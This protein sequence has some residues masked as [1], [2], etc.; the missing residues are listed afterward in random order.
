MVRAR[1]KGAI[2]ADNFTYDGAGRLATYQ[3]GTTN[4]VTHRFD[5]DI[6]DRV[7]QLR[8]GPV[9]GNAL[10]LTYSYN[11][12]SQVTGIA[13]YRPWM[14]QTFGYDLVD[15]LTSATSVGSY[16]TIGWTY[17]ATGNRLTENRGV[18]TGYT[19]DGSN[20][21]SG[22]TGANPETF[23]YNG[24]GE[25][26]ADGQGT[27]T[28][29]PAG[30]MKTATRLGMAAMYLYDADNMRV[31]RSV[32]DTT[33]VTLRGAGG[34]VLSELQQRCGGSL[35]WV[36]DNVYAGGKL[37]GAV[38]N[39]ALGPAT[40]L[41]NTSA[42]M[43]QEQNGSASVGIRVTTAN[44]APLACA[45]TVSYETAPGVGLT[46][47][48]PGPAPSGDYTTTAKTI[49]IPAG[50][51]HNAVVNVAVPISNDAT[52]E[53][54]ENFI[55]RLTGVTGGVL[56]LATG[57]TSHTVTIQDDDAPPTLTVN[58]ITTNE[59]AGTAN[60]TVQLSAPSAKTVQVTYTLSNGTADNYDFAPAPGFAMTGVLSILVGNASATFPVSI[61]QN[62]LA[63]PNETF[64]LNFSSPVN[65]TIADGAAVATIVDDEIREPIDPSLPGQYFADIESSAN[66][67]GFIRI[68]NPHAVAVS[69]KLTF[70]R[71]DGT[72]FAHVVSVPAQ[73]RVDVN[74]ST[75]AIGGTGRAAVAV[76]SL[77]ASRPLVSE[78]SGYS[79]AQTFA[80]GRNDNG[81]TPASNW[82][83]GEGVAK[84]P[85]RRTAGALQSHQW[86][87]VGVGHC[88]ASGPAPSGMTVEIPTGPGRVEFN[89]GGGFG[90]VGDH[91]TIA[92][93][94]V[95]GTSTPANIV[96]QRTMRWNTGATTAESSTSSGVSSPSINWF[97][98]D[99]NKGAWTTYLA[100]MNPT[101]TAS[102]VSLYYA[103]DNGQTYYQNVTVDSMR[104]VTVTPPTTMPD[105]GFALQTYSSNSVPYVVEKSMYSG[106]SWELGS[107]TAGSPWVY[108]T[109]RFAEGSATPFC[110]T[111]FLLF[112]PNSAAANVTMT[113]RKTDGTTA[114]HTLTVPGTRRVVVSADSLPGIS[115]NA[116]FA[117]E[118]NVTNGF[119]IAVERSMYWPGGAWTGSHSSMGRP[120]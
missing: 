78:Y 3:T 120:Q 103:H 70:V 72:G 32:N 22:T 11:K 74:L 21:L 9:A 55:V 93:A 109:W 98:G 47:A 110:D 33:V 117:T 42:S 54:D 8:A 51:A 46:P 30:M 99:G 25:L 97:F 83:F 61:L 104:R 43:V 50:T 38:K 44:G 73:K 27:Y 65:V 75:L 6:R 118:V 69:A 37:I 15:R 13:D 14:S 95:T 31:K 12:A 87:G 85:I 81:A 101:A 80:A 111:Y 77:D 53:Y 48:V 41:F 106:A 113:F 28:Y 94:V 18:T 119:S 62:Q 5:Y 57:A 4:F 108:N 107:S 10:D 96:V 29:S 52:D 56:S 26:T 68:F 82:S 91:G 40:F 20:R 89:V 45:A 63:E 86:S 92:T 114:T 24:V 39:N 35:E 116:A 60:F 64:H 16:G 105:G 100:F 34:Q 67:S 66:E 88:R 1:N 36:R 23:S 49:T 90:A 7:S 59:A 112:N 2:F 115:N 58:D 17:D 71:A 76:Q 84:G 19:Y 79:T 102:T